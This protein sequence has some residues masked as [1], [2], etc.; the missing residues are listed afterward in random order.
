M[1]QI[2]NIDMDEE[3]DDSLSEE[4]DPEEAFAAQGSRH[5]QQQSRSSG[6][7]FRTYEAQP[8]TGVKMTPKIPPSFD[9]QSSWFEFEDLIDDWVNITTL[10]AEKLGPSLK[11]ALTGNAEYYKNMLDNEQLRHERNG[12]TYF[13]ETL[14]PYFVKGA[15]HVFLWR[16]M[17]LFRTWRGNGEFVSW[18]AR[19]EVASKKVMEAF[20]GL[21][22]LST[23][24]QPDDFNFTDI[25]SQ[26]QYMLLQGTQDPAERR[27]TAERIRSEHIDALKQA[28]RDTFPLSDN[29]MSLIFLVQSCSVGPQRTANEQ[30]RERFV[31]SMALR[32][33]N[34]NNYTYLGVKGLFLDLFCG[35]PTGTADPSIRR[36][37]RSTFLVL[38]EGDLEEESG[39]WVMDQET[40]E[41]GFVSLFSE[42]AKGG[43]TR[44]RIHGR[45]FRK[46][47]KG[48]KG[49]GRGKGRR[50]GFV[51]RRGKGAGAHYAEYPDNSGFYGKGKKAGKKG[52][53]GKDAFKGKGKS[54]QQ[55]P[56]QQSNVATTEEPSSAQPNPSAEETWSAHEANW[57][58]DSY[59]YHTDQYYPEEVWQ[60]NEATWHQWTYFADGQT[61]RPQDEEHHS[62]EPRPGQMNQSA[63]FRYSGY[64]AEEMTGEEHVSHQYHLNPAGSSTDYRH[65]GC[66]EVIDP[67]FCSSF[68]NFDDGLHHALLSEYIDLRYSPT[69]VIIDSG[70]TRA[71]GSRT[72]IMRLVKA[73]KRHHNAS[74]IDFSFEPSS[75]RFSFA[76]GE[77]SNVREKLVIYFQND[78]SPT[79]WITTAIDILDQGDVPILFSIEQ[80]RNLRM[81]IEHTPVGDYLTCPLFGLK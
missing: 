40:G 54:K 49:K 31:A 38:D 3:H 65:S 16:F 60:A 14:R 11:N 13:K 79:G 52:F 53:K 68:V 81:S 2:F 75:S 32:Q 77:Q 43:Y 1:V 37:R 51:S 20:M 76:N 44:R 18:I 9:G 25:L 47:S 23:V 15:N 27:E 71:M 33:I 29:L 58:W 78:Q 57:S 62:S 69:Y 56:F 80:L 41:E 34:M 67:R 50:P 63:D 24:P 46:P 21:L 72:A 4:T 48:G 6:S 17:Q 26:Q 7:T 8:S 74:K 35:T 30:Q 12:I 42:S 64:N 73:C 55:N 39:Y 22:D 28:H 19:F 70:C 10:S 66:S 5:R 36:Q 45:R 59:G 61:D